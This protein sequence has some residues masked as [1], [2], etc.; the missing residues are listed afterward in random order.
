MEA[1]AYGY[2][3]SQYA[4]VKQSYIGAYPY[5]DL[6]CHLL[7]KY[8]CMASWWIYKGFDFHLEV[9]FT[10]KGPNKND[11]EAL[12]PIVRKL[13]L[14]EDSCFESKMKHATNVLSK[15]IVKMSP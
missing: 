12:M 3:I 14:H 1:L 5:L 6:T 8:E 7:N 15:G 11:L 13:G 2:H 4:L 9:L 10:Q